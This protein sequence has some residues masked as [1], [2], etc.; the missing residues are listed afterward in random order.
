M[1]IKIYKI[2]SPNTDKVYVGSTK[3][4]LNTRLRRHR[5]DYERFKLGLR[6]NITSFEIL[7]CGD[8]E[9]ELLT[10]CDNDEAEQLEEEYQDNEPNC[11]N[12]YRPTLYTRGIRKEHDTPDNF[13]DEQREKINNAP[14]YN[15]RC[16]L[17][18]YYRYKEHKLKLCTLRN[19]RKSG[20]LPKDV[21][22]EKYGISATEIASALREFPQ[23]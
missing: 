5:N 3:S 20:K 16:V 14:T 4:P 13:T 9:I 15:G 12:R 19:I 10:E 18:N 22:I 7:E 2:S 21:T 1:T 17:M 11:V 23:N 8:P 6:P